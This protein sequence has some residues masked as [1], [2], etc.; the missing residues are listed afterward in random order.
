[1]DAFWQAT[2]SPTSRCSA[3]SEARTNDLDVGVA[4]AT[5]WPHAMKAEDE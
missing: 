2:G 5:P 1:M 4:A 3:Q